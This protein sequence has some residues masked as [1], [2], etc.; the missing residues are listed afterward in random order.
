MNEVFKEEKQDF[1]FYKNKEKRG[2]IS[3]YKGLN[4]P[5]CAEYFGNGYF[6]DKI[7]RYKTLKGAKKAIIKYVD[8]FDSKYIR[9]C[10]N[11]T[12]TDLIIL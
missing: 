2:I 10:K 7:G 5:Y 3:F 1:V 12:I 9:L 6:P 4:K 11:T 8:D